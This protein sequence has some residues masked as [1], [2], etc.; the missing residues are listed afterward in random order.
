MLIVKAGQPIKESQPP[1]KFKL[2]KNTVK[3]KKRSFG[4]ATKRI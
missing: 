4:K 3:D 2:Y 1:K